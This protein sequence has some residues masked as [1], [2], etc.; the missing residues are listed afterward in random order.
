MTTK[1][2]ITVESPDKDQKGG[3]G[4]VA[5]LSTS[6]ATLIQETFPNSPFWKADEGYSPDDLEKQFDSE[7][8]NGEVEKG[9][10]FPNGF[11]R[12]FSDNEKSPAG[13]ATFGSS[14][15]LGRSSDTSQFEGLTQKI[16]RESFDALVLHRLVKDTPHGDEVAGYDFSSF[17]RDFVTNEA[18]SAVLNLKLA[19]PPGMGKWKDDSVAMSEAKKTS[20][21]DFNYLVLRGGVVGGYLL[22]EGFSRDY[23]SSDAVEI[24]PE[25]SLS[26]KSPVPGVNEL[27]MMHGVSAPP[28][29]KFGTITWEKPGDPANPFMPNPSS[30][31]APGEISSVPHLNPADQQ[32]PPPNTEKSSYK[33]SRPPFEG[34]GSALSPLDS[35]KQMAK[36]T[37]GSYLSGK[38]QIGGI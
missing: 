5:G 33:E 28:Q 8:M 19:P 1:G 2:Y 17:D 18:N 26:G 20:P 38:S 23:N 13:L 25:N 4:T 31:L 9:Y 14:P 24:A 16:S 34:Q 29:I 21:D 10:L 15:A 7:V 27:L 12:N 3:L 37:L 32:P 11:S 22:P 6:D 30:I 36:H 35:S